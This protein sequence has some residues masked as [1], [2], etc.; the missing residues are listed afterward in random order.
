MPDLK[1]ELSQRSKYW[2]PKH[3]YYEL[4]HYCLQYPEWKKKLLELDN[5]L[6]A[7]ISSEIRGSDISRSSE[8]LAIKRYELSRAME[9]V[10]ECIR[11]ATDEL[12]L[13]PYIFK[14]V[15][16]GIPYVQLQAGY[17]IPCGPDMYY[18]AYRRFFWL[19]SERKG[20]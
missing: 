9:L 1:P 14:A 11:T 3:R 18:D 6:K 8:N 20:I 19:L 15:T 12:K 10:E 13:Q 2:I 17:S 16:E 4:K 5:V 7:G